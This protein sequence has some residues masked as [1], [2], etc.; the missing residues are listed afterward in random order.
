MATNA[1]LQRELADARKR[2]RELE[3]ERSIL[4]KAAAFL[5]KEHT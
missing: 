4:E 3:M 2:I 1:D 5:A